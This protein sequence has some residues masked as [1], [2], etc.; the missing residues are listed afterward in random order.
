M[1]Q[2][3]RRALSNHAI[4][5]T[6]FGAAPFANLICQ[7]FYNGVGF[8]VKSQIERISTKAILPIHCYGPRYTTLISQMCKAWRHCPNKYPTG[9]E[10]QL[11]LAQTTPF[12]SSM[13]FH[14]TIFNSSAKSLENLTSNGCATR[15]RQE[16]PRKWHRLL[17]HLF[18]QVWEKIYLFV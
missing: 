10:V 9:T 18:T 3:A 4:S 2:K 12:G 17:V 13:V 11:H 1:E 7:F 14:K 15:C 16:V 6:I 5:D 8:F